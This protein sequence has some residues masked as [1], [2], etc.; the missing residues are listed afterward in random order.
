MAMTALLG[1]WEGRGGA[2]QQR[3]VAASSSKVSSGAAAARW[4]G[5]VA[6]MPV[7]QQPNLEGALGGG[8]NNA[9]VHLHQSFRLPPLQPLQGPLSLLQDCF[10]YSCMGDD[11][12]VNV[13]S[14]LLGEPCRL[15]MCGAHGVGTRAC[16]Q[17]RTKK[18]KKKE[19]KKKKKK[20]LE[21]VSNLK[22]LPYTPPKPNKKTK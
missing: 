12:P 15:T 1:R 18:K 5:G 17:R 3:S 8:R 21:S 20:N 19:K 4:S 22:K 2:K 13:G 16:T 10:Y 11:R 14:A 9:Y 6:Y 7:Q